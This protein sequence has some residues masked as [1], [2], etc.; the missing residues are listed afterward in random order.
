MR[1]LLTGRNGQV[2]WELER[3]LP[4]LGEVIATDRG[5]L[6]LADP[7]AIRRVVRD[8]RPD[9]IVNAAAYTAVDKAESEPQVAVK[10]NAVAPEILAEEAKRLGALV[11]HYSTDYVFD[12]SKRSPYV[13]TDETNPLSTYGRTKLEGELGI[14]ATGARHLI[15]RTEWI[16]SG[17]G[18]NF[19]LTM[20][21]KAKQGTPLR[22]I[23]DQIGSPTWARDVAELTVNVLR[24]EPP[25]GI[26]HASAAGQTSW[27]GFA[28]EI[29]KLAGSAVKVDAISTKEYPTPAKRPAYS[30]LSNGLLANA[31]RIAPIGDWRE[32]LAIYFQ[33][34]R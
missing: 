5:T 34:R 32:R 19:L 2:G 30:V 25:A 29:F 10:I 3:M 13:E 33:M 14:R 28:R 27:C 23:D 8:A 18:N 6:D 11:L 24:T 26:Y 4:A 20:L 16:Y 17:R 22:V 31:A 12:G 7:D 21:R 1:I 15:L 9:V